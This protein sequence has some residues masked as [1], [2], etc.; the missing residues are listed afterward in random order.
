MA[1]TKGY[2]TKEAVVCTNKYLSLCRYL[3]LFK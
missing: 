3:D 2:Y 1:I